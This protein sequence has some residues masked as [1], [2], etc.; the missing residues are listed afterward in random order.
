MHTAQVCLQAMDEWRTLW[1]AAGAIA[2]F[3]MYAIPATFLARRDSPTAVIFFDLSRFWRVAVVLA[4][5]LLIAFVGALGAEIGD[6]V[7]P[8][9]AV[10]FGAGAQ[11]VFGAGWVLLFTAIRGTNPVLPTA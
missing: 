4:A 10:F 2:F 5:L 3:V 8:A 6:P 11:G 1:G 9:D 7:R